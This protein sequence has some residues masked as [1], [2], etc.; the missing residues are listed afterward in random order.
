MT[1]LPEDPRPDP[2]DVA[3]V[4]AVLAAAVCLALALT[5]RSLVP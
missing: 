5:A 4:A 1:T 3:L 2:V